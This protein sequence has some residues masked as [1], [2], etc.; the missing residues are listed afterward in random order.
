[1]PQGATVQLARGQNMHMLLWREQDF[2][3]GGCTL[4]VKGASAQPGTAE[5]QSRF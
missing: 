3:A 2:P 5:L 1:M 4:A